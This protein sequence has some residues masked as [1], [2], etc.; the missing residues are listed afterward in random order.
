MKNV[1]VIAAVMMVSLASCQ[2][3]SVYTC[4]CSTKDTT[5]TYPLGKTTDQNAYAQ[6]RLHQDSATTCKMLIMK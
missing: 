2:H 3:E 5:V 1:L 4:I 6:C